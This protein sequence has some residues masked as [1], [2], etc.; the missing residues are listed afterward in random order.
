[1]M[2]ASTRLPTSARLGGM[3]AAPSASARAWAFDGIKKSYAADL[4]GG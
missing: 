4:A 1:V 3:K 2:R